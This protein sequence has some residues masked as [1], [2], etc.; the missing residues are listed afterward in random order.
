MAISFNKIIFGGRLSR[1][2]QLSCLPNQTS[3]VEFGLANNRRWTSKDGE[4]KE[5]TCFVDAQ[6]FGKTAENIN[7]Y[8]KKGRPIL[9]EGR[10]DFS[11]WETPE[12][13]KRS[14]HR[15]HVDNFTFVDSKQDAGSAPRSQD[16]ET[17]AQAEIGDAMDYAYPK[18]GDPF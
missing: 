6:A 4:Q 2:P 18:D 14:K 9:I 5:E 8:F 1:D 17:V 10:L 15:I 7:K 13:Q 16:S 12:G 3:V 11:Q